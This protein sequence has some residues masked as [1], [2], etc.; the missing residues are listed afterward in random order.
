MNLLL[1]LK[2]LAI[3][4]EMIAS[5]LTEREAISEASAMFG[6]TKGFIRSFLK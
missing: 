2:I 5:G 1:I 4:L 3:V 6:V